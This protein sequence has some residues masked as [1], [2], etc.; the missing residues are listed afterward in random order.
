MKNKVVFLSVFIV[1]IVVAF[2]CGIKLRILVEMKLYDIE[3]QKIIDEQ[4]KEYYAVYQN[5]YVLEI[6]KTLNTYLEDPKSLSS[7]LVEKGT[8]PSGSG[9]T[10]LKIKGLDSFSSDYYKGR[11]VVVDIFDFMGGGKQIEILFPDKPDQVF[12]VWVYKLGGDG[13]YDMRGFSE[14]PYW[15][16]EKLNSF[17]KRNQT[18]IQDK[19]HSL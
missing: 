3:Q 6:R 18:L 11:F 19:A 15:T 16:K 10:E 17:L 7:T 14:S 12:W 4:T 9:G 8:V 5:P 2:L 1:L 13:G